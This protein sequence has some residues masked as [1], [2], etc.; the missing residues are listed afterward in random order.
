MLTGRGIE[1]TVEKLKE[2]SNGNEETAVKIINQTISKGWKDLYEY[3]EPPPKK[4]VNEINRDMS[5]QE[6]K[7]LEAQ[8]LRS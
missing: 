6:I 1:L 5:V 8:L 3:K 7:D 2:L 4:A